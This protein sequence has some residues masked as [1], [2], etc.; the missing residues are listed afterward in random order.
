MPE[1][2]NSVGIGGNNEESD[3]TIVRELLIRHKAWLPHAMVIAPTGA[4]DVALGEAIKTFQTHACAVQYPDGR[5]DPRG[6]TLKR[7]NLLT[8]PKPS[9]QVF[10]PQC[11]GGRGPGLQEH[12]LQAAA[13]KLVCELAAIKAVAEVEVSSRGAWDDEFGRPTIL[14]ERH[15]F[16]HHTASAYDSTHKDISGGY[17]ARSYGLYRHQYPKLYRAAVLNESAALKSASWGAF[18]ILGENYVEAGYTTVELFV[19]A[20]LVSELNHL[21]AFVSFI[22]SSQQ[23][24]TA[25]R[26]K[27]WV[28]FARRYNGPKYKDNN[29]DTK[30]AT[31]YA[32][33]SP[34]AAP[35]TPNAQPAVPAGH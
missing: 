29:Y 28:T 27:D 23:L 7:L 1:I 15:K 30:L 3:V 33:H 34:P 8:I 5:V 25:I 18:Q 16:K 11:W 31:A 12:D 21:N 13:K 19:D 17:W 2:V 4:Y 35:A 22:Q 32:L 20:M 24:L 6:F 14:F 26:A 9:H 10:G